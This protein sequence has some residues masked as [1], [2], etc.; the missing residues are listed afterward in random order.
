MVFSFLSAAGACGCLRADDDVVPES[1]TVA[2]FDFAQ[3]C[4]VGDHTFVFETATL[5]DVVRALGSG[6]IRRNEKDAAGGEFFI[7]YVSGRRWVRFSSNAEMGGDDHQ[8]EEV[9]VRQL[10]NHDQ[11][12]GIPVLR[13]PVIFSF[14]TVGMPF[15]DLVA[16]LGPAMEV[17][18]IVWYDFIGKK[19][20]MDYAGKPLDG[21]VLGTL[22]AEIVGGRLISVQL[23]RVTSF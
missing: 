3:W 9:E 20:E 6:V 5:A 15:S 1:A 18:H 7:D 23:G 2:K 16:K 21:E 11:T 22:R 17:K 19:Q 13:S 4:K 10:Q 14:G 12:S 8:L